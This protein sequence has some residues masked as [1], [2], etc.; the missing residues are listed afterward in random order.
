MCLYTSYKL[1]LTSSL[2]TGKYWDQS[3]E[4]YITLTQPFLFRRPLFSPSSKYESSCQKPLMH[5]FWK[6]PCSGILAPWAWCSVGSLEDP[7]LTE[8]VNQLN[9]LTLGTFQNI[10]RGLSPC[11]NWYGMILTHSGMVSDKHKYHISEP[12]E[13][14]DLMW[15]S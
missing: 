8:S 3:T 6:V 5:G 11:R 2:K 10:H 12:A 7:E 15:C 9:C 1:F 14:W 4:A 13:H